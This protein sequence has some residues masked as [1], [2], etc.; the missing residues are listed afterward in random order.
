MTDLLLRS[1]AV[2]SECGTYRYRL[3]RDVQDDGLV[4]AYF[5]VNGSTAGAEVEDQTT[6]KW[7]VFTRQNGGRRYIAGNPFAYRATDVRELARSSDPVGPD[8]ARYLAE[9][10]SEADI[11]IPCWGNR[12]K[13]PERIR[14]HL[15][16]LKRL[17]FASGKPIK[18]FGFTA[19]GDPKHP[20]MLGY[21]TPL[22]DW[23]AAL[24]KEG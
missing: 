9:I 7:R 8:N 24:G 12:A 2:F 19:S 10:I 3:D 20:L 13:V 4:L 14:H 23:R 21:D 5:G 11:L 1:S 22:T 18:V 17:L 15:F 6:K 16:A